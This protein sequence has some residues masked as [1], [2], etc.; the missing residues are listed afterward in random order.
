[1]RQNILLRCCRNQNNFES[2]ISAA[3]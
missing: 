1:M 3:Y 2:K